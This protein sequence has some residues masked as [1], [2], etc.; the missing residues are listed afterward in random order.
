MARAVAPALDSQ[1]SP[2]T[3]LSSEQ[4]AEDSR[5]VAYTSIIAF[6]TG[7][8]AMADFLITCTD[9]SRTGPSSSPASP[10]A[11]GP[12][13]GQERLAW[14]PRNSSHRAQEG[15]TP[16]PRTEGQPPGH[17]AC[18]PCRAAPYPAS[19]VLPA[20]P[21][22]GDTGPPG[23]LA[24]AGTAAAKQVRHHQTCS[25]IG[26]TRHRILR[27]S[28]PATLRLPGARHGKRTTDAACA[29]SPGTLTVSLGATVHL[30]QQQRQQS[31]TRGF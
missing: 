21:D 15:E 20:P 23:L 31:S 25:S 12:R 11:H 28:R 22:R 10:T 8:G 16:G 24:P 6:A 18:S 19:P 17:Q 7:Y 14:S 9:M 27:P 26:T 2:V 13:Q 1:G 3:N 29:P 30:T 4:R 5:F